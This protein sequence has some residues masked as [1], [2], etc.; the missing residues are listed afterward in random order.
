MFYKCIR[1]S[2]FKD[3]MIFN[4]DTV[5]YAKSCG[6]NLMPYEKGIDFMIE[7][8][9]ENDRPLSLFYFLLDCVAGF[10]VLKVH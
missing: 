1:R 7:K 2:D 4:A 8:S 5:T 6:I 10:S 3:G 9:N